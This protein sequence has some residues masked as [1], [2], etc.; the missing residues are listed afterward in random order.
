[1]K[2]FWQAPIHNTT[3]WLAI[4]IAFIIFTPGVIWVERQSMYELANAVIVGLGVSALVKWIPAAWEAV[5]P[6]IHELR[7]SDYLIVGIGMICIGAV[8]RFAGQ[9]WWRAYDKPAGIWI[10]GPVALYFT[11]IIGVGIFL[12]F[13]PT[14]NEDGHLAIG[15][16]SRTFSLAGLSVAIAGVLAWAGWG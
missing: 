15:A 14:H 5:K 12:V 7:A 6:P 16:W 4:T 13:I 10:D 11:M 3:L 8:G 2:K 9:W 1:M